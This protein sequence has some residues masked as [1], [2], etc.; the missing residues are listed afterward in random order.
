LGETSRISSWYSDNCD[1]RGFTLSITVFRIQKMNSLLAT[2]LGLIPLLAIPLILRRI[3]GVIL[4]RFSFVII[5][6]FAVCAVI[7]AIAVLIV[8]NRYKKEE[9]DLNKLLK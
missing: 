4:F 7:Y 2:L 9:K 1:C 6:A 8:A 5:I 3:Y